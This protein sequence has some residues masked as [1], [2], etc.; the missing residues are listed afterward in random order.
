MC[1]LSYDCIDLDIFR[2]TYISKHFGFWTWKKV[3]HLIVQVQSVF[4][5]K[6]RVFIVLDLL[7]FF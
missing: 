6:S 3:T 4:N 5:S 1:F 2:L 7:R